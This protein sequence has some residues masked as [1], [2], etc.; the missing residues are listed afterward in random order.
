MPSPYSS[1]LTDLQNSNDQ[2]SGMDGMELRG[3]FSQ[4]AMNPSRDLTDP[5]GAA[6]LST[7]Q[8]N[9]LSPIE[10]YIQKRTRDL[11][12]LDGVIQE[13]YEKRWGPTKMPIYNIILPFF[14]SN[15]NN[16]DHLLNL[17][18]YL[19]ETLKVPADGTDITGS[20]ALYWSI[21]TKPYALPPFA[22]ILFDAGASVNQRN[23]F[24]A[25]TGGEIGQVD[26]SAD[27]QRNI[28][29]LR[30]YIEHGGDVDGK[31]N[32]GMNVRMLVDMMRK[33]VPG[34]YEVLER[35]RGER[36]ES[37]CRNCGREGGLAICKRCKGV[38]YCSVECQKVDWRGHRKGC[39]TST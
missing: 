9:A 38:R 37:V 6:L 29:M 34:M 14:I 30:W 12:S 25:T 18:R 7:C 16:S 39:K 23:R 35:G 10:T 26:F 32:D 19:A 20:S 8:S 31:D 33:K 22:Q 2:L 36:G 27:S 28:D 15:P 4:T 11:G 13:M 24:G 17:T 3:W 5:L 21:S 1:T